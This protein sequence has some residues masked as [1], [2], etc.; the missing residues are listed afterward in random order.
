MKLIKVLDTIKQLF[1]AIVLVA[2]VGIRELSA[3]IQGKKY[4]FKSDTIK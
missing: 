4:Y 2:Y 1:W 3:K